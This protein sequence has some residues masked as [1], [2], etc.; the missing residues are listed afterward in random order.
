MRAASARV[1]CHPAPLRGS[2]C[3]LEY[4]RTKPTADFALKGLFVMLSAILLA[5]CAF[6]LSFLLTPVF[7]QLALRNGWVD[8]P[9]HERKIHCVPIPRIGGV[10][11]LLAYAGALGFCS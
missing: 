8:Q 10:P 7:R 1:E 5:A 11:I 3:E 9:D 4:L 2:W 6:A